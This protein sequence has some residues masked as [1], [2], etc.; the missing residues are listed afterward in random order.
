MEEPASPNDAN[1]TVVPLVGVYFS[2]LNH[3]S[4]K[5][6]RSF[7]VIRQEISQ[8][9]SLAISKLEPTIK[10]ETGGVEFY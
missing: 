7:N 8:I 2:R 6:V 4:Q 1:D 5:V 3:S 10:D 9:L